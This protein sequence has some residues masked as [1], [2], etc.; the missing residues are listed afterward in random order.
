LALHLARGACAGLKSPSALKIVALIE[1]VRLETLSE[2]EL[3]VDVVKESEEKEQD[4]DRRFAGGRHGG[5]DLGIKNVVEK[6]ATLD[7]LASRSAK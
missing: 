3:T 7:D 5:T 2:P 4:R 1:G 6:M